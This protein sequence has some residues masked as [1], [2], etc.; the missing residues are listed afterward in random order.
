MFDMIYEVHVYK[1][2]SRVCVCIY[3]YTYVT[4]GGT[5][6]E[7]GGEGVRDALLQVLVQRVEGVS[8]DLKPQG[9]ADTL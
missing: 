4:L 3:L 7:E 2:D 9:I 1:I 8:Q 6:K 5:E